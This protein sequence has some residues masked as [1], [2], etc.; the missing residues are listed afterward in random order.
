L[1]RAG[2]HYCRWFDVAHQGLGDDSLEG[3]TGLAG[4]RQSGS[5]SH[6]PVQSDG[7]DVGQP[8]GSFVQNVSLLELHGA[9][10]AS[11]RGRP[12][13]PHLPPPTTWRSH[14]MTSR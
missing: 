10:E 1:P 6:W 4:R 2:C 12:Y 5:V 3:C 7:T 9:S 8:D 13:D 14:A 11:H